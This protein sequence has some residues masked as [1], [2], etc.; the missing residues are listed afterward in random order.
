MVPF[1]QLP[2]NA[3]LHHTTF[4][5]LLKNTPV[6]TITG[7]RN[8][9][10][11]AFEKTKPVLKKAG[12]NHAGTIALYDKHLNLVS[13]FTIFHWMLTGRKDRYL[14][15]FPLPGVSA[16]DIENTRTFG[17]TALPHLQKNAWDGLNEKLVQAKAVDPKYHLLFIEGKAA[18]MF[19]MWAKLIRK[20]RN[21]TLWLASVQILSF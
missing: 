15:F 13:I 16:A 17:R 3:L 2:F 8:M 5:L 11:T 18:V 1:A 6:I 10:A 7:A 4:S 14:G 21:K 20:K 19:R 9:W 12:A